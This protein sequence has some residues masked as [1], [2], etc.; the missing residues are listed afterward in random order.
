[1]SKEPRKVTVYEYMC[2]VIVPGISEPLLE[3]MELLIEQIRS[4]ARIGEQTVIEADV[5]TAVGP[6]RQVV[7]PETLSPVRDRSPGG[8]VSHVVVAAQTDQG[9]VRGEACPHALE[10]PDLLVEDEAALPPRHYLL[11]ARDGPAEGALGVHQV[12]ADHHE[13][14]TVR[15]P[16]VVDPPNAPAGDLDLL[17]PARPLHGEPVHQYPELRVRRQDEPVAG[18]SG[19]F[20]LRHLGARLAEHVGGDVQV[21]RLG[22]GGVEQGPAELSVGESVYVQLEPPAEHDLTQCVLRVVLQPV[23]LLHDLRHVRLADVT[24]IL[25][26]DIRVPRM[27]RP[28]ARH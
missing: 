20:F 2:G 26:M 9:N 14:G 24:D 23:V 16:H 22:Q 3:P 8:P 13:Q 5:E 12:A 27:A 19:P 1:M 6:E 18:P 25:D 17:P 10:I 4:A 7:V 11:P 21:L 15:T 28:P